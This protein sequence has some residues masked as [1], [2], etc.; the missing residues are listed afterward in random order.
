MS[1]I[2][3]RTT[4]SA[5]LLERVGAIVFEVRVSMYQ[6]TRRPAQFARVAASAWRDEVPAGPPYSVCDQEVCVI[7]LYVKPAPPVGGVDAFVGSL[8]SEPQP[9]RHE[10]R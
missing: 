2:A 9:A 8:A 7:P 6:V 1:S 4:S 10:A 5:G 3:R